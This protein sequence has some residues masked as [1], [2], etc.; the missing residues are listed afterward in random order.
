MSPRSGASVRVSIEEAIGARKVLLV[1]DN[2][3]HVLDAV[4]EMSADFLQQCESLV[5]PRHEP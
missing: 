4:A 2:C 1:L 5:D 3:E